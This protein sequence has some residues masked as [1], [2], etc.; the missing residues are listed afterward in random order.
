MYKNKFV[1]PKSDSSIEKEKESPVE[2]ETSNNTIV[3]SFF[4]DDFK[5]EINLSNLADK[6]IK[7]NN[8]VTDGKETN[9]YYCFLGYAYQYGNIDDA[10]LALKNLSL[11]SEDRIEKIL[12]QKDI[13]VQITESIYGRY[14]DK[15]INKFYEVI[16]NKTISPRLKMLLIYI[17]LTN[18]FFLRISSKE[19]LTISFASRLDFVEWLVNKSNSCIVDYV[20]NNYLL[21]VRYFLSQEIG[22][23]YHLEDSESVVKN[24]QEIEQSILIGNHLC[25]LFSR[26]ENVYK[27]SCFGNKEQFIASL[28]SAEC[29]R[30]KNHYL[31]TILKEENVNSISLI[32]PEVMDFD[33]INSVLFVRPDDILPYLQNLTIYMR[34]YDEVSFA[35]GVT[36]DS[37]HPSDFINKIKQLDSKEINDKKSSK[38]LY[39]TTIYNLLQKGIFETDNNKFLA[40]R[41]IKPFKDENLTLP[42]LTR[43]Y[44]FTSFLQKVRNEPII[45]DDE[46]ISALV[47]DIL[48][49]NDSELYKLTQELKNIINALLKKK[50]LNLAVQQ[51]IKDIKD[52]ETKK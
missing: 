11:A 38:M 22:E 36:F 7:T 39:I 13:I 32:N 15:Y 31:R 52:M 3:D 48:Y 44:E 43:A 6:D 25:V 46:T 21:A 17:D 29:V 40:W 26:D 35:K 34:Y 14:K 51:L 42:E 27:T 12:N 10:F 5:P 9:D 28:L 41:Q 4:D 37:Y 19:I 23:S 24:L 45:L 50:N 47:N 30:E 2:N 1:I 20:L 33:V 18:H 8:E 49:K 16:D